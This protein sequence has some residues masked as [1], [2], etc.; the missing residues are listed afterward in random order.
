MEDRKIISIRMGATAPTV[1]EQIEAQGLPADP[2]DS[3]RW[4]NCRR[5]IVL[6]RLHKLVT[7]N[8]AR[9]SERKLIK[10]IVQGIRLELQERTGVR[11]R[12]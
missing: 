11:K 10:Q 7:E 12:T 6:L 4:E 9:N 3:E 1:G 2:L 5:A 8:Q